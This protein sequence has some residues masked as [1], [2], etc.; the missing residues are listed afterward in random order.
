MVQVVRSRKVWDVRVP[1]PKRVVVKGQLVPYA[2]TLGV[3]RGFRRRLT[4]EVRGEVDLDKKK[5]KKHKKKAHDEDEK[6]P[7]KPKP[8]LPKTTHDVH[9]DDYILIRLLRPRRTRGLRKDKDGST[10]T[11]EGTNTERL[12]TERLDTERI[13]TKRAG[14][15]RE[16][17]LEEEQDLKIH[18]ELKTEAPPIA[19]GEEDEGDVVA[20]MEEDGF[21]EVAKYDLDCFDYRQVA[22]VVPVHQKTTLE[23]TVGRGSQRQ[24]IDVHFATAEDMQDCLYTLLQL[25]ELQ[26]QRAQLRLKAFR[27]FET[28]GQGKAFDFSASSTGSSSFMESDDASNIFQDLQDDLRQ[29]IPP[30]LIEIVSCM[31]LPVADLISSD[32]Y[33]SVWLG[34]DRV[35]KTKIIMKTLNPVFTIKHNSMFLFEPTALEFFQA[36]RGVIFK[37]KDYDAVSTHDDLGQVTVSQRELLNCNGERIE[38]DLKQVGKDKLDVSQTFVHRPRLVLRIRKATEQDIAFIKTLEVAQKLIGKS[39]KMGVYAKETLVLPKTQQGVDTLADKVAKKHNDKGERLF[40]VLPGPDPER[41]KHRTEYLTNAELDYEMEKPSKNWIET[42]SGRAGKVYLEVLKCQNLPNMD[43]AMG[44]GVSKTDAFCTIIYEDAL[45]STEVVYNKLNPKWMPWSQRA[46]VFHMSHPSSQVHLGVFDHD[47][48]GTADPIGRISIDLSSLNSGIEYTMTYTLYQSILDDVRPPRGTVTVR[49]RVET[50]KFRD[51]LISTVLQF[52]PEEHINVTRGGDYATARFTTSGEENLNQLDMDAIQSYANELQSYVELLYYLERA[53]KTLLLWR[54]HFEVTMFDK[55]C[56]LPIHSLVAFTMGVFLVEDFERA[57]AFLLWAVAWFMLAT[58]EERHRN[59]DPWKQCS[60]FTEM[61]LALVSDGRKAR[62][63]WKVDDKVK[64]RIEE[65]QASQ[66]KAIERQAQRIQMTKKAMR[67]DVKDYIGEEDSDNESVHME[68]KTAHVQMNVLAPVLFPIQQNLGH[69]CI[70]LRLIRSV[71]VWDE[72]VYAF[73]ITLMCILGGFQALYLPW[74]FIIR[75]ALRVGVW[76]FLGPWMKLVDVYFFKKI[77]SEEDNMVI[78]VLRF[79]KEHSRALFYKNRKLME[80][81][82]SIIQMK[83]IKKYMFGGLIVRVPRFKENR[84]SDIPIAEESTAVPYMANAR[85]PVNVVEHK[86]GQHLTGAMVPRWGDFDED[87]LS[88]AKARYGDYAFKR[89]NPMRLLK[90]PD[91]SLL[92]PN[93][94]EANDGGDTGADEAATS[95]ERHEGVL[96]VVNPLRLFERLKKQSKNKKE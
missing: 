4:I 21:I 10:P 40:H 67:G 73:T 1:P 53:L 86:Y 50:G 64:E 82:E 31:N 90:R 18:S 69:A 47:T 74:G 87:A 85:E 36:S 19:P 93:D 32:P 43:A 17:F 95:G 25:R 63:E 59:P 46:F 42:G 68:T 70:S 84:Y 38:Y 77:E 44:V 45:A 72:P 23:V 5:K 81:K 7:L 75:Q 37:V 76:V 49:L 8:V 34:R 13:D 78:Q 65:Y 33:V 58:N 88:K 60:T 26:K 66:E 20:K 2:A 79:I 55:S 41:P 3:A 54:G 28:T 71:V 27:E 52:A 92:L 48:V 35:H 22:S 80:M 62:R 39:R 15:E 14:T 29:R 89:V 6:T 16:D 96:D 61:L 11:K 57:P 94:P 24:V 56:L 30:L 12:E 9:S 83:A 51:E 91:G